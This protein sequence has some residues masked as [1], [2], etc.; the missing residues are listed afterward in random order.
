MND[1]TKYFEIVKY[2]KR[3]TAIQK[4]GKQYFVNY[5]FDKSGYL[6][7][8]I[9]SGSSIGQIIEILFHWNL[10]VSEPEGNLHI[11]KKLV[12]N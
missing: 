11:D 3:V 1:N 5:Y 8:N 4:K 6:K 10:L 9:P 2:D 7:D 12:C